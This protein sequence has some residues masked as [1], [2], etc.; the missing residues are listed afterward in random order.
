MPTPNLTFNI[1]TFSHPSDEY[2]FCFYK[3]E[4]EN[5]QRVHKSLVPDEVINEFGDQDHYYTSFEE[6]CVGALSVSKLSKP[7][8]NPAVDENGEEFWIKKENSAFSKSMLKRF[9]IDKIRTHFISIGV[10]V[11]AN[12]VDDIEVWLPVVINNTDYNFFDKYT[13]KI[14]F[15]MVSNKPE[16]LVTYEGQSKVFRKSIADLMSLV[17]PDCFN[18]VLHKNSLCK[19]EDLTED[20]KRNYSE[21]FPVLNFDIR[22]ALHLPTEAPDRS[23]HYI[24]YKNH[25]TFFFDT[26]LNNEAFKKIIP[27]DCN[28][29]I[30]V[31]DLNIGT[32]SVN[33][34][35]LLFGDNK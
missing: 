2:T 33:T 22:D 26:C 30:P 4:R 11:K 34:N 15:A 25:I 6:N 12:F 16:I 14:Q 17:A 32:V 9:Y 24:R 28:N 13:L 1:L 27:I 20:A 5:L 31:K 10:I 23:N 29:F 8:Y 21:V 35:V 18:W 3:D 19:Y 7:I